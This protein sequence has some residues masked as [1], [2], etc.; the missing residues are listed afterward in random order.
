[1]LAH[2]PSEAPPGPQ[3]AQVPPHV[4]REGRLWIGRF[5]V[6]EQPFLLPVPCPVCSGPTFHDDGDLKCLWCARELLVAALSPSGRIKAVVLRCPA[7]AALVRIAPGQTR[8]NARAVSKAEGATGLQARVLR[9]VPYG[10]DGHTVVE[11]ISRTLSIRR[12]QVRGALDRLETQG[13]VER[14][15]FNAGYRVGYRRVPRAQLLR[16]AR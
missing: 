2:A 12:E 7:E 9:L 16:E 5:L 11:Q 14:F 8:R 1:M 10:P 13:L 6:P 3:L 4:R 15:T